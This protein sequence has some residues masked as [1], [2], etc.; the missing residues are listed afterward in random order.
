M[1]ILI[2]D[3][4]EDNRLLLREILRQE[5]HA[6]VWC[7]ALAEEAFRLL[8][9]D[10]GP[11]MLPVDLILMDIGMPGVDGVEAC[12]RIRSTKALSAIQI[13]MVTAHSEVDVLGKSF[14]AGAI[15][16]V[17]KPYETVELVA[18]VRCALSY[19]REMDSRAQRER[20]LVEMTRRL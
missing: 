14:A 7:V 2:V 9:L 17:T 16:Y 8:G 5:G 12:R 15:D 1:G 3:D 6:D 4:H 20:E 10:G 13:I 11:R 19:K 18:R